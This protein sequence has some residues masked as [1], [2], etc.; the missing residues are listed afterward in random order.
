MVSL[1]NHRRPSFDRLR[2]S[3]WIISTTLKRPCVSHVIVQTRGSIRAIRP[4]LEG[5]PST[6][7]PPQTVFVPSNVN[8]CSHQDDCKVVAGL[9]S[10]LILSP[11]KDG[12]PWFDKLTMS[13]SQGTLHSCCHS[14]KILL[15]RY[16]TCGNLVQIIRYNHAW[17]RVCLAQ[18]NGTARINILDVATLSILL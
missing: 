1:S 18:R 14:L 8:S 6:E 11:S 9:F 17:L 12:C 4:L 5:Q 16:N 10:P 3:G 15:R 7:F 2:T 13:R